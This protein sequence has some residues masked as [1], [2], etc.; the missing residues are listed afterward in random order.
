MS[1]N[2]VCSG[3]LMNSLIS[4]VPIV[5]VTVVYDYYC[6]SIRRKLLKIVPRTS[7]KVG[8][9]DY[10]IVYAILYSYLW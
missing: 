3:D 10:F 4:V 6:L 2:T 9:H 8:R 5:S 7:S 1:I